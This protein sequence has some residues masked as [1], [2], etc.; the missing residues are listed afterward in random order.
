MFLGSAIALFDRHPDAGRLSAV[1]RAA[2]PG[3]HI[4]LTSV[5]GCAPTTDQARG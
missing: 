3:E 2:G 1:A 4:L 5:D